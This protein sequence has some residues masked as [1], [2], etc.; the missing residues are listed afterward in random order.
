[1]KGLEAKT[2]GLKKV[3]RHE[4]KRIVAFMLTVAMVVTNFGTNLTVAF[5]AGEETSSLF[6]LDSSELEDAIS[7]ALESGDVFDFSSLELKAKQK[8]LKTSY[9]KL[10]GS[11]AGKVYQLDVDVDNSYASENTD[12]QVFY[13]AGTDS[14]VFLFINES[15]MA[16]TFRANVSGY[17]TARVTVNPNTSNIEDAEGVENAEDYSNTTMVDDEKN[18]PKAEVVKPEGETSETDENGSDETEEETKADVTESE[19]ASENG[20]TEETTGAEN[21]SETEE[22]TA[23]EETEAEVE[24]TAEETEAAE[25]ETEAPAAE[26]ELQAE[27]GSATASI[28]AKEVFRVST[29]AEV[30]EETLADSTEEETEAETEDKAEVPEK[31]TEAIPE[32]T[33]AE[34]TVAEDKTEETVADESKADETTAADETADGETVADETKDGELVNDETKAPAENPADN[35]GD[36]S[37]VDFDGDEQ[38]LEDDSIELM[39]ELAGKAYNT[40]TIWGRANAR[41]YAVKAEDLVGEA[42]VEGQY[43]VDYSVDPVGA[44]AIKGAHTVNE[45]ETLYFAVDPQVG[46]E[47]TEV[48]ANGEE[49]EEVDAAGVASA[50]NLEKYAH[51]YAVEEVSEDLEIVARLEETADVAHP[52]FNASYVGSDGVTIKLHAEEGIIPEGTELDVTEVTETLGDTIKEKMESES[53]GA[54]FNKVLAYDINLLYNGEKLSNSWSKDGYV[55]VTFTGAPIQEMTEI[56]DKV[57]IVAVDDTSKTQLTAEKAEAVEASELKLES[58]SEQSVEGEA[59]EEVGFKAEHFTIYA[60]TASSGVMAASIEK[61][62]T[63]MKIGQTQTLESDKSGYYV[64]WSSSNESALTVTGRG[65]TATVTAVGV[66]TA[67]ITHVY[68]NYWG[69]NPREDT[70]TITVTADPITGVTLTGEDTVK[71]FDSIKLTAKTEPV[72]SAASSLEWESS[73]TAILT[74]DNTG[75]VTG[76]APGTAIVT[77]HATSFVDAKVYTETKEITVIPAT[78]STDKAL[79]YYLKTPTSDPKSN[80]RDQWGECI[81]TGTITVTGGTWVDSGKNMYS[82]THRVLTWPDGSTGSTWTIDKNKYGSHWDAIFNAYKR[83]V[84]SKYNGVTLTKDDIQSITLIPYKISRNNSSNP[85]KHVDCQV[86]IVVKDFYNAIYYVEDAG[87]TGFQSVQQSGPYRSGDTTAPTATTVAAYPDTKVKNG[88]TYTFVGWY[89]NEQFTGNVISFPYAMRANKEFYAKYVAGYNVNYDLD[90]GSWN[91]PSTYFKNAD[92][93][94]YVVGTTPTKT[95]YDFNGWDRQDDDSHVY[96]ANEKFMMPDN[97]VTF[98]AKWTPKEV[99]YTVNYYWAGTT[100]SVAESKTVTGKHF[101]DVIN[102]EVPVEAEGYTAINTP[103]SLTLGSE[104]NIINFY[105]YKN[106]IL[107]ANSDEKT[108]NG[109]EQNVHGYTCSV[110]GVVFSRITAV[111][112]GTDAAEY[113]STFTENAV[114]KIDDSR[115]YI[116]ESTHTGLLKIKPRSVTVKAASDEKEYDGIVLT[117]AGWSVEKATETTGLVGTDTIGSVKVTGSQLYPGRSSNVPSEASFTSGKATNYQISYVNGTLKVKDRGTKYV[118]T[119]NA[120]DREYT[121]DGT[122]KTASGVTYDKL[123]F[124]GKTYTV[125]GLSSS[126]TETD[127]DPAGYETTIVG[128]AVVK[129]SAGNDVTSQF[130]VDTTDTGLLKINPREVTVT[131]ASDEKEY[132]GTVLTNA[133][134]SVEAATETTGLVGTDTIG[135]VKVTGSQLYPGSSSNVPSEASFTSGKATNYQISYVNGTLKVKDRGTKYVITANAPDREYTYDGTAKTA[136]GVTYDKLTFGGKTYT[137]E[138]L[139]SSRTETDVDPTGNGYVTTIVGTAVVKDSDGQ[140]VTEQFTVNATD[141][142]LLKINPRKVTITAASDKKQYDGTVLVSANWSVEKATE[143]TGLVGGDVIGTV[144][145]T[146]SQLQPGKSSNVPS[147]AKFTVGKASNYDIEYVNG[148]LEITGNSNNNNGGEGG[149]SSSGGG[150]SSSGPRDNG[151]TP[152]GGPGAT[153][154]TIDPDAV[155][156]ANLPNEDGAADLLVIDDEDVPLAALPK[157]GQSGASGLVLFLSSMMLAAFVAVSKKREDDK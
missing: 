151:S 72:G 1:M 154:V 123:T 152:S 80:A 68:H 78:Q 155:P 127:A 108:Y 93:N 136:S 144:K 111:A 49:L 15:E 31:E 128:T 54:E 17:E 30:A 63:T 34:E 64:S 65:Q 96:V 132:D 120:P 62:N 46:Y 82:P 145:V 29:S 115:R 48:T 40:V 103:Q 117:N 52:E 113:A 130:S 50:S 23:A 38:F 61:Y 70:A 104:A 101:G 142:G 41:A 86:R 138:G 18:Q 13:N 84:E 2:L 74:V 147:D 156:L 102:D 35:N 129:D 90:G 5:A 107:T 51:V 55:D 53:E 57:E 22:T 24:E 112:N 124:G 37:E 131:A 14:V 60:V 88:V 73:N 92:S 122:A 12:L 91:I 77:V 153:T 119:A 8:S 139:S 45:G 99:S 133:G 79:F 121:Y 148:S 16:V 44:A 4:Y 39:G 137:V 43:N 150:G 143:N 146:G 27:E 71:A 89:D 81:G 42:A 134:W 109:N 98:K 100:T 36:S 140:D 33:E 25:P 69:R 149:G 135:D 75:N 110:S 83:S 87:E 9:E 11:K 114:G 106:V 97:N 26:E 95:G 10:I 3:I 125:E 21:S 32:T 105:Y 59:V 67:T 66:G 118:I 47:I 20:E 126:R 94:V 141:T 116:V 76:V 85:D 6:L 19:T 157:T 7:T 28:S 58:V 56:S